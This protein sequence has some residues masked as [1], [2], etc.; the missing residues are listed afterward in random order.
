MKWPKWPLLFFVWNLATE[1]KGRHDLLCFVLQKEDKLMRIEK[2]INPLLDDNDQVAFSFILENIIVQMKA[3]ENVRTFICCNVLLK[4][5]DIYF[6]N[7]CIVIMI[8]CFVCSPGPS[9]NLWTGSLS[10]ITT[11]SSNIRWIYPLYW[12]YSRALLNVLSI[13]LF[14]FIFLFI[15]D[16]Q[17]VFPSILV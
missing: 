10:K 6:I 16:E 12:R 5:M 14:W 4:E 2:A 17:W 8:C 1:Y 11:T 3:I 9:I 15:I 7:H 13:G